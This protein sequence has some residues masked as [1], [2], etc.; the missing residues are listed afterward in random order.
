MG[1]VPAQNYQAA[2]VSRMWKRWCFPI[3]HFQVSISCFLKGC[4]IRDMWIHRS[5]S[6]ALCLTSNGHNDWRANRAAIYW[7]VTK[8]GWVSP[9][10][11][12]HVH[13]LHCSLSSL[14]QLFWCLN[15]V[16]SYGIPMLS[17]GCCDLKK[18]K[19]PWKLGWRD[20]QVGFP[21][22][23]PMDFPHLF[24]IFP[25]CFHV[26]S[27]I[28]PIFPM[29]FKI[30]PPAPA[31]PFPTVIARSLFHLPRSPRSDPDAYETW[32]LLYIYIVYIYCIIM[33][34]LS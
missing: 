15:Q 25:F 20:Q 26:F 13:S 18:K 14:N 27:I 12:I 31:A 9:T 29:D 21:W 28:T 8:L 19:C 24:P 11:D 33:S 10:Y 3:F 23:F 2:H 4:E 34:I 17:G 30:E 6:E 32:T 7:G 16:Y 22:I 1:D 5:N